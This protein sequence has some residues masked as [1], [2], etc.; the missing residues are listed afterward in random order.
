MGSIPLLLALIYFCGDRFFYLFFFLTSYLRYCFTHG[1]MDQTCNLR[2][3]LA[4]RI[5]MYISSDSDLYRYLFSI[6]ASFLKRMYQREGLCYILMNLPYFEACT[7]FIWYN[8]ESNTRKINKLYFTAGSSPKIKMRQKSLMTAA[9]SDI[10]SR[11][12]ILKQVYKSIC[13]RY[14]KHYLLSHKKS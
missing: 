11:P 4:C 8:N 6:T 1:S 2:I 7:L 10:P 14:T 5:K 9:Y 3:L 13:I 12:D